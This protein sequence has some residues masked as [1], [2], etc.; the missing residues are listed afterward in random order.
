TT[1]D[2]P[3]CWLPR[4]LCNSAGGHSWVPEGGWGPLSGQLLHLSYGRCRMAY[5][6]PPQEVGGKLQSGAVDLGVKFLSGIFRGRFHPGDGHFYACG[7]NGWQTAAA[8]DGCLQRV[9]RTEQ[10]LN[11]PLELH[12]VQNGILVRFSQ[13]LDQKSAGD[14]SR[15]GFSQWNYRYSGEYGSKN[16][17]VAQPNREGVDVLSIRK[18]VLQPDDCSVF[19]D[20][21]GL[22]P[23]MQCHLTFDLQ[24]K[25]GTPCTGD[26][27]HTIYRL[28]ETPTTKPKP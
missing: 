28:V 27:Y 13:P 2:D 19:L 26:I 22:R 6:F 10:P 12:A 25:E 15:Y 7:L 23:A 9:R 1:Y 21:P 18:A 4:S 24:T 5:V 8:R 3:V 16:W 14:V 20:I 11:L 17:S